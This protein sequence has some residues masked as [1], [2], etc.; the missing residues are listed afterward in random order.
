MGEEVESMYFQF[1]KFR[2]DQALIDFMI[3]QHYKS[4]D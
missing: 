2:E 3:D 1:E 4:D